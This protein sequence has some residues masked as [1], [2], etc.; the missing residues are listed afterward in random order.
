MMRTEEDDLGW[1]RHKSAASECRGVTG[2]RGQRKKGHQL[3]R[4]HDEY[5]IEGVP[6][7]VS[8]AKCGPWGRGPAVAWAVG[9][10]YAYMYVPTCRYGTC[11]YY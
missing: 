5:R 8:Y 2:Q 9:A 4:G 7:K 11:S 1:R 6:L 3:T 10:T